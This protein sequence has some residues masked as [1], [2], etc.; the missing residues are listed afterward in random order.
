MCRH[1]QARPSLRLHASDTQV[2]PHPVQNL[3][4]FARPAARTCAFR[5]KLDVLAGRRA[6]IVARCRDALIAPTWMLQRFLRMLKKI[7]LLIR[8]GRAACIGACLI[9]AAVDRVHAHADLDL[10]LARATRALEESPSSAGPLL[11]RAELHRSRGDLGAAHADLDRAARLAPA[12]GEI[13]LRR[14]ELHLEQ[15]VAAQALTVLDGLLAADPD[16]VA[17]HVARG[18]ALRRLDRPLE[19]AAAYSEALERMPRGTPDLFLE[20]ADALAAGGPAYAAAAIASLDEGL[21]ALGPLPALALAAVE[22]EVRAGRRAAALARVEREIARSRQPVWWMV[23]KA[24]ILEAAGRSHEAHDIAVEAWNQLAA[25]PEHRRRQRGWRELE[26]R[27]E[28]ALRPTE[29][30]LESQ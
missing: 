19:A 11:E 10:R 25:Q 2:L 28:A 18:Q 6:C 22:L 9:L 23:R 7:E 15:G 5:L 13:E 26:A 3:S 14:A 29:P 20:R 24:E 27:L 21:A 16:D 1:R 30:H 17:A 8:W 12:L 4:L